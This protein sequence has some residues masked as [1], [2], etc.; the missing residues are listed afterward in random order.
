[1]WFGMVTLFPE[2]FRAITGFGITGRAVE[3]GLVRLTCWNPRDFTHDRHRT[4]DDS[5]YGGG[6]GM[7]LKA[8]PVLAAIRAAREA[9]PAG[10]QVVLMSPQGAPLTQSRLELLAE[11]PGLVLV[12]GRYEG[13]DERVAESAIDAEISV[14]DFV[15]SG[16]EVP[17]MLL[18]D[19]ITRLIPGVVG[20][21]DSV[22]LDSFGDGLLDHP[23][24]TRPE[25]VEGMGVPEVLLSGDHQAIARWREMQALGRT[26]ERRPD[27]LEDRTLSEAQQGLLDE[28]EQS[29]S[30]DRIEVED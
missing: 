16:G 26:R 10:T 12:S 1:M 18:V 5:P 6:P 15:V 19:G 9:A 3:R 30:D 28:Y 17:S 23:H 25:V 8:E 29:G 11:E 20:H 21:E 13:I 22:A 24:Y 14:G 4:V 27:L 2:M 7:V